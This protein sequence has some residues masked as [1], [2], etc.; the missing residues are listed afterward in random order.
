MDRPKMGFSIPIESWLRGD[1]L[2]LLLHY[3]DSE[4]VRRENILNPK[5]VEKIKS[6]FLTGKKFNFQK[7]WYILMFQMWYERWMQG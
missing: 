6:D 1:F 5:A 7:L 2:D 4:K 3:M